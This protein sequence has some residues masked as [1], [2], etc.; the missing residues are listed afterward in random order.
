MK[1]QKRQDCQHDDDEAN[2]IDDAVHMF[3]PVL[4]EA[5]GKR[6][7]FSEVPTLQNLARRSFPTV[8][9]SSGSEVRSR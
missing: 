1:A 3:L 7:A 9:R 5:A 2:E 4:R 8:G 6:F